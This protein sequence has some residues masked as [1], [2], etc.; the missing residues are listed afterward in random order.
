MLNSLFFANTAL[1]QDG[2]STTALQVQTVYHD[3]LSSTKVPEHGTINE[4]W[5][6]ER[7]HYTHFS[8]GLL[9]MFIRYSRVRGHSKWRRS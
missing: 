3:F 9:Y 8:T 6:A 1:I 7:G 5:S 4:I 2:Q